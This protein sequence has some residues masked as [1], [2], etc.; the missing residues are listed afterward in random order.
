MQALCCWDIGA[1]GGVPSVW[2]TTELPLHVEAFD[3]PGS[4]YYEYERQYPKISVNRHELILSENTAPILFFEQKGWGSGSTLFPP[5]QTDFWS[6]YVNTNYNSFE[7]KLVDGVALRDLDL[8][9][10]DLIKIDIQGAELMVLKGMSHLQWTNC[11]AIEIEV[12]FISDNSNTPL[13]GEIDSFLRSQGFI[14]NGMRTSHEVTTNRLGNNINET[15]ELEKKSDVLVQV[16]QADCLY[17]KDFGKICS[18]NL[19]KYHKY[20][21]IL[22]MY[23]SFDKMIQLRDFAN[24]KGIE[25]YDEVFTKYCNRFI[26]KVQYS[27]TEG[28]H[29]GIPSGLDR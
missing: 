15:F 10:P 22:C 18:F 28:I 11:L 13:Y 14:I 12:S 8:S 23:K 19:D 5:N 9:I 29:K 17:I 20:L 6:N 26:T 25:N 4:K 1:R 21:N 24:S 27:N 16:S 3:A 2:L 7:Q